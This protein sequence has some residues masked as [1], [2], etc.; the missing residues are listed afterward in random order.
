MRIQLLN[1]SFSKTQLYV[2]VCLGI[3]LIKYQKHVST[4][5]DNL[6]FSNLFD[7]NLAITQLKVFFYIGQ[8]VE[9]EINQRKKV[10]PDVIE[11]VV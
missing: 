11:Q 3:S 7:L 10:Q 9:I 1:Y 5:F 6:T 4:I 2:E 8:K